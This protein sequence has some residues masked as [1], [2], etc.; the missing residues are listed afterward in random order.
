MFAC[1]LNV[2]TGYVPQFELGMK[3]HARAVLV[4]LRVVRR[5]ESRSSFDAFRHRSG[6]SMVRNARTM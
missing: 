1:D 4:L 2:T 6:N 5:K 3:R